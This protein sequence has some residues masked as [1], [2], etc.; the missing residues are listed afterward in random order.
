MGGNADSCIN[1]LIGTRGQ[2]TVGHN[3]S[4]HHQQ[5]LRPL[6][7]AL[8]YPSSFKTQDALTL[9]SAG[10]VASAIINSGLQR[11]CHSNEKCVVITMCHYTT[12]QFCC[13]N[14]HYKEALISIIVGHRLNKQLN[15]DFLLGC[16][17]EK[18]KPCN[19]ISCTVNFA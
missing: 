17:L 4:K 9:T 5:I 19:L 16:R 14:Y 13:N 10:S 11:S 1:T 8:L 18:H 15:H 6:V 12:E 2:S 3:K 7:N